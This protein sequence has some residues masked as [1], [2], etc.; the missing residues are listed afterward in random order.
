M[1][2]DTVFLRLKFCLTGPSEPWYASGLVGIFL[3]FV[4]IVIYHTFFDR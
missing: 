4:V 1:T 2:L 3:A